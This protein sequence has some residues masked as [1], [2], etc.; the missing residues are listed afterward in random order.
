MEIGPEAIEAQDSWTDDELFLAL[1]KIK[2]TPLKNDFNDEGKL[3]LNLDSNMIEC[4]V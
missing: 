3:E 2:K 1:G 4:C